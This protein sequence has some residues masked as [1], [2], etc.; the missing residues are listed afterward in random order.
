MA[1]PVVA[2]VASGG[3]LTA[4]TTHTVTFDTSPSSGDLLII[5]AVVDSNPTVT[6]PSGFS[7]IKN[8]AHSGSAFTTAVWYKESDGTEG[9][10]VTFSTS[11]GEESRHSVW[12]ITGHEDPGTQAPEI[13]SFD[14]TANSTT[15]DPP[16]ISPTGGSKDYLI[17]AGYGSD[18]G[19][20]TVSVWPYVDNNI[21]ESGSNTGNG[22]TLGDCSDEITSATINPGTFTS[23]VS[24]PWTAHTIAIH[25]AAAGGATPK[26]R[27]LVGAFSGPFG[28]PF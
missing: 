17:L 9:T 19:N 4:V 3:E 8:A 25:P 18:T 13:A 14:S 6:G 16:S 20:Q 28:G 11:A 12:R 27:A 2:G 1:A 24:R 10:S 22:V 5:R 23:S 7:E 15:P 21:S 26:N